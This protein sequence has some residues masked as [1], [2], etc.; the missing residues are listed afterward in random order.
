M[1]RYLSQENQIVFISDQ[2]LADSWG[3]QVLVHDTSPYSKVLERLFFGHV[4]HIDD[5]DYIF[6]KGWLDLVL[7]YLACS[8]PKATGK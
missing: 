5:S 2:N 7:V 8:I 4:E 1:N 6:K 3:V